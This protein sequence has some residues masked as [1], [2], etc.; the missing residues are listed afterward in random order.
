MK[1]RSAD[2]KASVTYNNISSSKK[3]KLMCN[4]V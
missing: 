1:T 3:I 4:N 2:E